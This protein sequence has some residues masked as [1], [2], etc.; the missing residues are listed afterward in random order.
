[1]LHGLAFR[2]PKPDLEKCLDFFQIFELTFMVLS[3]FRNI[4]TLMEYCWP[5]QDATFDTFEVR[6]ELLFR[7]RFKFS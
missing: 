5:D 3:K 7:S 4:L 1:M 6:N 2:Q